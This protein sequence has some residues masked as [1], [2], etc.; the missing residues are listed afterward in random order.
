MIEIALKSKQLF[1]YKY[2]MLSLSIFLFLS[3]STLFT[4]MLLYNFKNT[5]IV[6]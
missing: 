5:Y 3:P 1:A 2:I 6:Q 4:D